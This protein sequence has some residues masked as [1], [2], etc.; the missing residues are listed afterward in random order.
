MSGF[1]GSHSAAS[2]SAEEEALIKRALAASRAS[3]AA[4]RAS[5]AGS[6]AGGPGP[7]GTARVG[8]HSAA[9]TNA[10]EKRQIEWALAASRASGAG[11]GAG[12]GLPPGWSAERTDEGE[13]Y[14]EHTDAN[15][16]NQWEVPTVNTVKKIRAGAGGAGAAASSGAGAAGAGGA[17]AAG[18]GGA[19]A[20]GAGG[21]GAAAAEHL[22]PNQ[23][24]ERYPRPATVDSQAEQ[25]YGDYLTE[26]DNFYAKITEKIGPLRSSISITEIIPH[27]EGMGGLFHGN[28]LAA[29]TPEILKYYN[30]RLI[31]Q[32]TGDRQEKELIRA[33]LARMDTSQRPLILELDMEDNENQSLD[34]ILQKSLEY[35]PHG[36]LRLLDLMLA[37]RNEGSNILVNCSVGM[38]RST[39]VVLMHLMDPRAENMD[40]LDAWRFLKYKR[41]V[42]FPN[43]GF[44]QK[45]RAYEQRI[46]GTN[47]VSDELIAKHSLYRI[48]EGGKK[49]RSLKTRKRRHRKVKKTRRRTLASSRVKRQ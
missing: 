32:A 27:K 24:L 49:R 17:G 4:S 48:Q 21:A 18:A 47:T 22:T 3:G 8:T 7:V 28:A 11:S 45:L 15:I 38:S 6:G 23:Y 19:G 31:I 39:A 13:V 33:G 29:A 36:Q 43:Y 40:L 2:T 1:I 34:T 30:I 16:P 20:A 44:I 9:R 42:I 12:S 14:Y 25:V 35:L 37:V 5:G 26:L 46:R 41:P 10:E